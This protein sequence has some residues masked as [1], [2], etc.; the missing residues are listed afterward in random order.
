MVEA[1]EFVGM[2]IRP[3]KRHVRNCSFVKLLSMGR[4]KPGFCKKGI[5][6]QQG[7][8]ET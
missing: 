2:V 6:H 8:P 3:R 1:E 5:R 4:G 7:D